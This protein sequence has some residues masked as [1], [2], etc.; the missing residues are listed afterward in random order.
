MG[1]IVEL[2]TLQGGV[3]PDDVGTTT[4]GVELMYPRN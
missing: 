4:A 2:G 3:E 1:D